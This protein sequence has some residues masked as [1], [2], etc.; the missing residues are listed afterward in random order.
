[1]EN[2]KQVKLNKDLEQIMIDQ[3]LIKVCAKCGNKITKDEMYHEIESSKGGT[4][5]I[6][7]LCIWN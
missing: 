4:V 1:M 6:C 7:D 3:G 2:K 5:S